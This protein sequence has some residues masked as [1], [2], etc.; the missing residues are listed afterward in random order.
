MES[1]TNNYLNSIHV[2]LKKLSSE[3]EKK[4][5]N[6]NFGY[7]LDPINSKHFMSVIEDVDKFVLSTERSFNTIGTP[8]TEDIS[9]SIVVAT[10]CNSAKQSGSQS[11]TSRPL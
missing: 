5:P 10:I 8:S 1:S 3:I 2:L 7:M 9:I 11:P 4:R 6:D